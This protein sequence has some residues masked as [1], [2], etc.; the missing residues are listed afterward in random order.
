MKQ[1]MIFAISILSLIGCT[2]T[3]PVQTY[4]PAKHDGQPWQ[5]SG[6]YDQMSYAVAIT[7]NGQ[8]AAKGKFALFQSTTDLAG[9][10]ADKAV[11]AS[12]SKIPIYPSS[13][14]YTINCMVFVD[15]ERAVTLQ[16]Q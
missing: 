2:T 8:E 9:R 1:S 11:S 12:C 15:S 16:F 10:Y 6:S 3:A 5:I 7:I 4:R 14:I 13:T